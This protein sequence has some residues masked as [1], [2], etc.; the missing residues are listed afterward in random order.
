MINGI[1]LLLLQFLCCVKSRADLQAENLM[2][3]HQIGVLRRSSSKRVRMTRIDRLS[4]VW[5]YRLC[6]TSINAVQIIHPKTLVRWHR[7]GFRAYWRR[8]SR[9]H[10][11]RPK[12]NAELR[13]LILQ[14]SQQNPLWGAPRLHGE[15]LK[16]GFNVS[17]A[18]VS[19]YL[20][21]RPRDPNQRWKTFLSN[22]RHC[23]A[24]IDFLVVPTVSFKLLFVLVVLSHQRRQLVHLSATSN[25]TADWTAQQMREAFPW[26][27]GPRY[28]IHDRD[29]TFGKVFRKRLLAMGIS[30][31]PTAPRSPWQNGHVERVI[32]S[33]RRECLDHIIIFNERHLRRILRAYFVYYNETRTHLALSKDD[34]LPRATSPPSDGAII[35]VPQVGGLHHRYRRR[36]A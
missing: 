18:T 2:L 36:A 17:Q 13:A 14:M 16:L 3:R 33:I 15:L 25:P 22:H 28:L 12:V 27:D 7:Q 24:S 4:F 11:G 32:G 19:R 9:S 30:P 5:L 10:G 26:D 6:P 8:K 1:R 29:R 31:A 23:V 20:P 35:A 21:R 34:P